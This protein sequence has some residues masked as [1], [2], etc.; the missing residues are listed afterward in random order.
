MKV[1]WEGLRDYTKDIS[2]ILWIRASLKKVH[3]NTLIVEPIVKLKWQAI[4][5]F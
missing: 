2:S 4:R 1:K 3:P 5:S